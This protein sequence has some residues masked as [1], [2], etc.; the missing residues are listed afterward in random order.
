MS[1]IEIHVSEVAKQYVLSDTTELMRNALLLYPSIAN[2][3]ISHG[4]AAELL[5][6]KKIELI[7]LYSS[8]GIPYIDMSDEEF[9]DE[10]SSVKKLAGDLT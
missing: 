8:I 9:D 3:T 10:I 6:V 5:G 4:R 1:N 7:E 2:E